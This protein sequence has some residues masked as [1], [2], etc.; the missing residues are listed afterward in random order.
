MCN[1]S[2]EIGCPDLVKAAEIIASAIQGE[3]PV[4][5]R[6]RR[7]HFSKN[8]ITAMNA[9]ILGGK[10]EQEIAEL[11]GCERSTVLNRKRKLMAEVSV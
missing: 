10:D 4:A 9:M 11:F 6:K 3:T 5:G 8:D 2:I 7:V 1:I